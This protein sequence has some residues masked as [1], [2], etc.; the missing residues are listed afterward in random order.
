MKESSNELLPTEAELEILQVLW[1]KQPA[2]VRLV[3][4]QLLLK[5]EVGYTTTLKQMQRMLDKGILIRTEQEGT[6]FYKTALPQRSTQKSMFQRL[7]ESAFNGSRADLLMHAL[8]DGEVSKE[9]LGS[10]EE[11]IN[12]LKDQMK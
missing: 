1:E 7:L 11:L 2:T 6:H 4:E 8:G 9:E 5:K 10:L 3:H 12:K